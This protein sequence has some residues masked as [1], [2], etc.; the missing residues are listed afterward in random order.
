MKVKPLNNVQE[1]STKVTGCIA[2][3]RYAMVTRWGHK[4][5]IIWLRIRV[6]DFRNPTPQYKNY[7]KLG[8]LTPYQAPKLRRRRYANSKNKTAIA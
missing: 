3:S 8:F 7:A 4:Q 2:N 1:L 5:I 6:N